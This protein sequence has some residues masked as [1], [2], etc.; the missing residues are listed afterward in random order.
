MGKNSHHS[1]FLNGKSRDVMS[2]LSV[3]CDEMRMTIFPH[4][5]IGEWFI[6]LPISITA[7]LVMLIRIKHARV[8]F[9]FIKFHVVLMDINEKILPLKNLVSWN[10][11]DMRS[12]ERRCIK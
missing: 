1:S 11:R 9:L 3:I 2:L 4:I 8:R 6:N 10:E 5:I 12:F 7:R